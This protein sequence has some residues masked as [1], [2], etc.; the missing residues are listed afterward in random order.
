M[1]SNRKPL[2][3]MRNEV[4]WCRS[5]MLAKIAFQACSFNHSDIWLFAACDAY[6]AAKRATA[7]PST[8][9]RP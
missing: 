5:V 3:R 2:N 6:L 7:S 1:L 9:S 4:F 8:L